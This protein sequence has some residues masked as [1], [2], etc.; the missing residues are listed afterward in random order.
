MTGH[1]A[2]HMTSKQKDSLSWTHITENQ[3]LKVRLQI[4]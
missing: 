2:G 3:Q 1:M 4:T